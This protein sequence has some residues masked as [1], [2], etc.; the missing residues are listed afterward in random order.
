MKKKTVKRAPP[1]RKV[2][3]L[4][5]ATQELNLAVQR[6]QMEWSGTFS[7]R[8]MTVQFILGEI[9]RLQRE[10]KEARREAANWRHEYNRIKGSV[11]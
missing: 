6:A 8:T 11:A 9:S 1:A 10:L 7:A 3:P 4:W 5:E 2:D